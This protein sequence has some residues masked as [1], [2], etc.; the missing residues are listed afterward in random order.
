MRYRMFYAAGGHHQS[1]PDQPSA[2]SAL[3]DKNSGVDCYLS[4]NLYNTEGEGQAYDYVFDFDSPSLESAEFDARRL[5]EYLESEGVSHLLVC[6]GSKGY[7]VRVAHTDVSAPE[8]AMAGRICREFQRRLKERL[9]L[10]TLDWQIHNSRRL[11][12]IPGTINSKSG[13]ECRVLHGYVGPNKLA[14]DWDDLIQYASQHD[15][16]PPASLGFTPLCMWE[17]EQYPLDV[18]ARSGGRSNRN[19]MTYTFATMLK[20]RGVP[21]PEALT[22]AHAFSAKLNTVTA[23]PQTHVHASTTSCVTSVFDSP[24]RFSCGNARTQGCA[25]SRDCNLWRNTSGNETD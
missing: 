14:T 21:L 25:C 23:S 12:R 19:S 15:S 1:V 20:A 17:L 6:S 16:A 4:L 5:C 8:H 9:S 3:V 11:M 10:T 7:H 18:H 24:A 2:V 13:K 22:R